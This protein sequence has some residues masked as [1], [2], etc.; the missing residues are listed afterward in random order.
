M[1]VLICLRE[2][3]WTRTY[4]IGYQ[5]PTC[6]VFTRAKIK[7][8]FGIL[9]N[10]P[11]QYTYA[12][13]HRYTYTY[14]QIHIHTHTCLHTYKHTHTHI[15]THVHTTIN[16]THSLSHTTLVTHPGLVGRSPSCS[17]YWIGITWWSPSL[18]WCITDF[19]SKFFFLLLYRV[20]Y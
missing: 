19:N 14:A 10:L 6:P 7:S 4:S 15:W 8:R 20:L 11:S 3:L 9:V 17:V 12:Q 18:S 13:I 2:K 16:Y 5:V 1:P